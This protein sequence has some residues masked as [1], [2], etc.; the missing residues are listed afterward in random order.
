MRGCFVLA[1][2]PH[3]CDAEVMD[4]L[5]V[6]QMKFATSAW[7]SNPVFPLFH[8]D[9]HPRLTEGRSKDLNSSGSEEVEIP[10]F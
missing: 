10:A 5:L 1:Q 6:P 2:C 3:L 4:A 8:L 9:Y 7:T